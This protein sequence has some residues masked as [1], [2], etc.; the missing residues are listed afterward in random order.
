[1]FRRRIG[2][3]WYDIWYIY[4][5]G[6]D[7]FQMIIFDLINSLFKCCFWFEFFWFKDSVDTKRIKSIVKV[8]DIWRIHGSRGY[9]FRMI[10][11]DL[12]NS[13]FKLCV[14]FEC[15]CF[16]DVVH[17]KRINFSSKF[18]IYDRCMAAEVILFIWLS[19][20]SSIIF[21]NVGSGYN[22]DQLSMNNSFEASK[23]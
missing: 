12:I 3:V 10:I 18:A 22:F 8:C 1:M 9:T 7:T 20:I 17:T 2:F 14:R 15:C 6:G 21:S 16:K 23:L 5:Y 11:S 13:L 4:V 19:L